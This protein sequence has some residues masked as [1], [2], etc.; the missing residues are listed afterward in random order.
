MRHQQAGGFDTET[1]RRLIGYCAVCG[2]QL[3]A[4][5]LGIF[6]FCTFCGSGILPGPVLQRVATPARLGARS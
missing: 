1:I 4:I 5:E 2:Q 6:D 3:P